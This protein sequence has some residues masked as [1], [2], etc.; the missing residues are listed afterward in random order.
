L[1]TG[2]EK[3]N[4]APPLVLILICPMCFKKFECLRV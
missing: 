2:N 4:V 3:G 1:N